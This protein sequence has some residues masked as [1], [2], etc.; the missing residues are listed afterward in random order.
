M[1]AMT[2]IVPVFDP[3]FCR[4]DLRLM[5]FVKA[6]GEG[7]QLTLNKLS[8]PIYQD[9]RR[10]FRRTTALQRVGGQWKGRFE[11]LRFRH[12]LFIPRAK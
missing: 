1:L 7:I 9:L 8:Y 2:P 11:T 12:Q 3:C 5:D 6:G 4:L 10:R